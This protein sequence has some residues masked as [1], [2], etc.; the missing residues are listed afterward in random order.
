MKQNT[1]IK[2]YIGNPELLNHKKTAFLCSRKIPAN[3]ILKCYDWAIEQR[4]TGNCIIS[5]FHSKIE[6]DVFYYLLKGNQPIIVALARGLKQKIEPAL[7][8]QIDNERLLIITPFDFSV[9][10]V[11]EKTALERN[12]FMAELA[13][14]IAVGYIAECG[15]LQSLLA[16]T[17]KR[18]IN[19]SNL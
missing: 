11:T 10:R 9:I 18:I 17:E 5:G 12:Q 4:E 3:A 13:D 15:T 19:I 8:K 14:E 1:K 7:R 6:K 16:N 2:G